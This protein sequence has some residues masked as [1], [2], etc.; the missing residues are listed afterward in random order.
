MAVHLIHIRKTGGTA[1]KHAIREIDETPETRFGRL[2]MHPHR[3]KLRDLPHDDPVFF[4]LRDPVARFVSGF[5]SRLR[6]GQPRHFKEWSPLERAAFTVFD[7]PQGLAAALAS[8]HHSD[9]AAAIRAMDSIR[10]VRRHMTEWFG[11]V[12]TLKKNLQRV[13]YVARQETLAADWERI[14]DLLDLPRDLSL[15][16][17]PLEAHRGDPSDDRRLD[18]RARKALHRWYAADYRLV[19]LC[20]R[21]RAQRGWVPSDSGTVTHPGVRRLG[22]L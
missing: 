4:F 18:A 14:K 12:H 9:H 16:G 19:K 8:R 20:D 15:P 17:S 11:G 7:S 1:V 10:H 6:K 13:L 21:V 3:I 2:Y 22:S 5:Y